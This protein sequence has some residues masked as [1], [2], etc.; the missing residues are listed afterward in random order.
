MSKLSGKIAVVT[1]GTGA[2]GKDVAASLLEEG[3]TVIVTHTG[4]EDSLLFLEEQKKLSTN[5]HGIKT[6]VTVEDEVEALFNDVQK[7]FQRA[8][9]LCNLVGG[10]GKKYLIEETP[11]EEWQ[12][13]LTLN[14]QTTFLTMKNALPLMKEKGFGRV[15]NMAAMPAVI[16]DA[17]KGGYS[18]SKAGVIALTRVA[19][20]EVKGFDKITVNA[21]APGIINTPANRSWG[22]SSEIA[23]WVTT[24]EI[25]ALI[26]HLCSESGNSINGQIINMFGKG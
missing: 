22:D 19:A 12:R 3:C 6:D 4:S 15:I 18:V 17:Q 24:E 2:L 8:D 5:L 11:L 23:K 13:M 1:G 7:R 20:E 26:V 10:I 21:I 9:I 16:P 14:L 25:S